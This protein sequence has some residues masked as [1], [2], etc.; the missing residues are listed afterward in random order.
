MIEKC[1]LQVLF[2]K[3]EGEVAEFNQL[4]G[5]PAY[6]QISGMDYNTSKNI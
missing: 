5:L 3:A 2:G 6:A 4:N 1:L